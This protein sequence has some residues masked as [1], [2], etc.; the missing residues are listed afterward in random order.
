MKKD[1]CNY[2]IRN[3]FKYYLDERNGENNENCKNEIYYV[4]KFLLVVKIKIKIK[5]N[6]LE[7]I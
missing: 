7:R 4:K 6:S 5:V 1:D 3:K 2:R